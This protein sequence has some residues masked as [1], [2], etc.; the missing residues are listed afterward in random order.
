MDFKHL[1]CIVAGKLSVGASFTTVIDTLRKGIKIGDWKR[2]H[3]TENQDLRNIMREFSLNV[4]RK[5]SDDATSVQLWVDEMS[6]LP[7]HENPILCYK[8][9]G[10]EDPEGHLAKED[11]FLSFK[12]E[13]PPVLVQNLCKKKVCVDS[14]HG[15]NDYCELTS[16]MTVD[17][18][19]AG[20]PIAFC[21]TNRK[22]T[23]TWIKFF[24]SIKIHYGILE[25]EVFMSDDDP[26]FYNAWCSVMGPAE[27][28]LLCSWHINKNLKQNLQSKT[29]CSQDKR[30]IVSASLRA[31]IEETNT[32]KFHEELLLL[33]H[34]LLLDP[35]LE[36]FGQYFIDNYCKRPEKWAYCYRI[37]AGINTNMYLEALHKVFKYFYL[38]GR[39]NKRMDTCIAALLRF[40][41]DKIFNR[42]IMLI[43]N[44]CSARMRAIT[45]HHKKSMDISPDL[46]T[47]VVKNKQWIISSRSNSDNKYAVLVR[48]TPPCNVNECRLRCRHC[49]VCIHQVMCTCRDNLI[50]D[51]LCVHIH[52]CLQFSRKN[53]N[54]GTFDPTSNSHA[55][56]SPSV[57]VIDLN[58][59][60]HQKQQEMLSELAASAVV[61][62]KITYSSEKSGNEQLVRQAEL[63]VYYLKNNSYNAEEKLKL[64]ASMTKLISLSNNT[65]NN[66]FATIKNAKTECRSVKRLSP[67]K[68]FNRNNH[69]KAKKRP[70]LSLSQLN[71]FDRQKTLQNIRAPLDS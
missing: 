34:R 43:K 1:F 24:S 45:L 61:S 55:I 27:K 28:Q 20:L 30:N 18:C 12:T 48:D 36:I 13:Y 2:I 11:F 64:S 7:E 37:N 52:A 63:I 66:S 32:T 41:R 50:R 49:E 56:S 35:E 21:L 53:D 5:H 44:K 51:T 31:V 4:E 67:Q 70:S 68:R 62:S 39:K 16:A 22:T 65:S 71:S 58:Q 14:T 29:Q 69:K 8:P 33:Q 15:V 42:A 23:G 10:E 38:Q 19:G 3:L 26:A 54:D 9:V 59:E 57:S 47:T 17:E 40:A 6:T 60:E 25:T 46:I